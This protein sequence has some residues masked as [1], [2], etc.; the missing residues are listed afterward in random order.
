MRLERMVRRLGLRFH[1]LDAED[2]M[3]CSMRRL[4]VSVART[5]SCFLLSS[6]WS[7]ERFRA[8]KCVCD[9]NVRWPNHAVINISA[10]TVPRHSAESGFRRDALP[11]ARDHT[12]LR[13]RLEAQLWL[14]GTIFSSGGDFSCGARAITLS[15]PAPASTSKPYL[16]PRVAISQPVSNAPGGAM[17]ANTRA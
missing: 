10:I 7:G 8:I 9:A 3:R 14:E 13:T 1:A 16:G 12:I 17:P 15:N 2:S 5:S 11:C 4:F 6:A